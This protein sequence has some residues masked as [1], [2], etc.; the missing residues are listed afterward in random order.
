MFMIGFD[1]TSITEQVYDLI[2]QR[3]IGSILLTAKNLKSKER[4]KRSN[5]LTP[6]SRGTHNK[7]RVRSAEGSVRRRPPRATPDRSGPRKWRGQQP[8]RR[9]L[10]PPVSQRHG[11]RRDGV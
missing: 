4:P 10:H 5:R 8:V 11:D 9:D 1:G 6:P 3:H 7:T 2:E